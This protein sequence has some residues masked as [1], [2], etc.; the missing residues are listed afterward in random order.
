[1]LRS[2]LRTVRTPNLVLQL[3][4]CFSAERLDSACSAVL[5]TLTA[6][7]PVDQSSSRLNAEHLLLLQC[8]DTDVAGNGG[9]P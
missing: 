9:Q 4:N 5:S 7:P 8:G 1:M 2:M 6:I 3:P